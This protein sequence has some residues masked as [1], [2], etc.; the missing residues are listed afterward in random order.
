MGVGLVAGLEAGLEG[1]SSMLTCRGFLATLSGVLA[2]RKKL[3]GRM[4][5]HRSLGFARDDK[6]KS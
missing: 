4:A 5:H 1:W 2:L 6:S 3:F